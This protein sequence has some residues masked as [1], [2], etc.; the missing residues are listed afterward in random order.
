MM[1][2]TTLLI[3]RTTE[4]HLKCFIVNIILI[5][6]SVNYNFHMNLIELIESNFRQV[7]KTT[8]SSIC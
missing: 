5:I 7:K 3:S 1:Q 2:T 8:L 4:L 6:A